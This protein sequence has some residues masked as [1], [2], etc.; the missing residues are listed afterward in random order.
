MIDTKLKGSG[1]GGGGGSFKQTPDNL[2][3]D[4]T[5]EGVLGLCIGP[6]KGPKRG[7]K[8]IKVDGTAIENENGEK[9]LGDFVAVL[10]DGDPA[11]HPQKVPLKLGAG[12]APTAVNLA[13]TNSSASIPGPWITK[14][15][16]N[17]G[18]NFIDLR[19]IVNQLFRQ[20]EKGIFEF[21]ATLDVE[22]KPT[23]SAT[24]VDPTANYDV[25]GGG[26][27][28]GS[29][30][31]Y[32][33][34]GWNLPGPGGGGDLHVYMTE[35]TYIREVR[36]YMGDYIEGEGGGSGGGSATL[37]G[38]GFKITAKRTGPSV[39]ELRL[40][41]PSDGAYA[42]KSWDVRVRL[43]E[44]D[45]FDSEDGKIQ[46]RRQISWE[47]LSAVYSAELGDHEDWRGVAWLQVYG[48]ASEQ[49]N[50]VPEMT[51]EYDCKIVSVPATVFDPETRQYT[52]GIWDGSWSKAFTNDPAWVINDAISD[53]LSGLA[54]IASG[55]YLNKWD[56]LE[57]SKW[58]SELV[59]DGHGGTHPRYSLNI[60]ISEDVKAEEFIRNLAGA[61][62]GLAWD[63]GDGE[64]RLKVDKP[65]LPMDIFTLDNVEGEF[66]YSHTDVDT[67]FNDITMAFINAEMDYR[68][69]RVRL[70]DNDH[71]ARYGRKPTSMVAVGCTNRQEALRRT[72]LRLESTTKETR[73]VNFTTNRRGRNVNQL[74]MIL[75]ADGDL[76]DRQNR[77]TGRAVA[78]SP[79]RQTITLR[80]TV[81][82]EVGVDYQLHF[83][84]PN[85]E[86]DPETA[87]QPE[88]ETWHLPTLAQ[89]RAITNSSG[90]RG[91]VTTLYLGSALPEDIPDN[92]SIS[93]SAV[94]LPTLPKL[95][96]VLSVMPDDTNPERVGISALEVNT[97]KWDASDN[98]DS[99]DTVFQDLRGT[100]PAP[101]PPS[102]GDILNLIVVPTDTGEV[103][104]LMG[105]YL[106]PPSAFI[107]GFKIDYSVN[108]GPLIPLSARTS[109]P[110]FEIV[111]PAPGTY[112]VE[113]RSL[114]RRGGVS[115][116]LVEEIEV[117][118]AMI[119]A[120]L[121]TYLDGT[122]LEDLR[123]AEGGA[124]VGGRLGTNI[125]RELAQ[126]GATVTSA[127]AVTS[128]G[129]AA[130]IASQG[131]L[132]TQ[133]SAAYGS[134]ITG[135]PTPI[136]P[137]NLT[138][139][140]YLDAAQMQYTGG[141]GYATIQ[142]LR[143]GEAGANITESR[144]AAAITGQGAL[145]TANNAAWGS[146]ITGRPTEL[147]DGRI[148][149]GLDASGDLNRN[150]STG[151]ANTSNLLR[152]SSGGLF[153]GELAADVTS[154]H[155]AAAITGQGSL[156]T[157]SSAAWGTH[158]SG[159]P[160]ELTD[161]RI[162]AGLD[163]SG[164]LN[165]N[166]GTSRANT[167]NLLRYTSG[168]LFT[169]EL[170]ADVTSTH[171]AAAIT[172]QGALA[173]LSTIT[174]TIRDNSNL[175]GRSGGG[176]YTGD[177]GAT[178][179]DNLILNPSLASSAVGWYINP[180]TAANT[181]VTTGG[182]TDPVPRYF[183][184]TGTA[185][186][187]ANNNTQ[188]PVIGGADLFLS[189]T[190]RCSVVTGYVG[191][192]VWQYNAAG[193]LLSNPTTTWQTAA[194]TWA[195]KKTKITLHANAANILVVLSAF[196]GTGGTYN[197]I[198]L[199]RLAFTEKDATMG[200]LL[201]SGGNI[202][203]DDGTTRLTDA[204]AVT[205]LGTA[206]A[207]A[208]QAATATSSDFSVITGTTRPEASADVTRAISGP[209]DII[210][211][212]SHTGSYLDGELPRN[213]QF[214]LIGADG[215]DVT[216]SATWTRTVVSGGATCTIGSGTGTLNTTDLTSESVVRIQASYLGKSWPP[217][218]VQLRRVAAAAPSSG[219]SG[220][221]T[222]GTAASKSSGLYTINSTS[223]AVINGD[224][225]L[226]VVIGSAGQASLSANLSPSVEAASP[227]GAT[228]V[229]GIW[230]RRT[231][232][233]PDVWTNIDSEIT[234]S[235]DPTSEDSGLG[236]YYSYA[237]TLVVNK[238]VTG[239]SA[240]STQRFRFRARVSGGNTRTVYWAAGSSLSVQG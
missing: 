118:Q 197:D 205:S 46:E 193:A 35:Q 216:T 34:D 191:I 64:W 179:G 98:V 129:T 190:V 1:G 19:F 192:T 145:A 38:D 195:V 174:T 21:T 199:I 11:K 81:R 78:V 117:T 183:R 200:G 120:A 8:S 131:A 99:E 149:A 203:R 167:S 102:S 184:F 44:K 154:T 211:G 155:T 138:P 180:S 41:V 108:G 73:I 17:T 69:D 239:L 206:A 113:I 189:A 104:N 150:I 152:Y 28:G 210:V 75:I 60:A 30:D 224:S 168:G 233:G 70:F 178:H 221:G 143:P 72:K 7:M 67:R 194:A 39:F 29:W 109:S 6:I 128:L 176:L 136:Q 65:E 217:F 140:G 71:I 228:D 27:G 126:G 85:P 103:V 238:T 48:K 97:D 43:R 157:L 59:P 87:T 162:T 144:T 79:D 20:T 139:G 66:L 125:Y 237:G 158:I 105:S 51:G 209:A 146:Q 134:Q 50:S 231:S 201:G 90:Q 112:R 225:E 202:Y 63:Q 100:P 156:A 186:T 2:R 220:G 106:R 153:T 130:A 110:T 83:S 160:T 16:P 91:N 121:L 222:G 213:D 175:L 122:P 188:I 137:A 182:G 24:W 12:A 115:D 93:L 177:L 227:A 9:N 4:D 161:G 18:A 89:T 40:G 57:A 123:P 173:T 33:P 141:P 165:R 36:G 52:G 230:Q 42:D 234:S 49:L 207:I 171:T 68:E 172:G 56:A 181:N 3:S 22:L 124:T 86:Y 96:R 119:N 107:S 47:S 166:I 196:L 219:G 31:T 80:D 151:R 5:F 55:S 163:A 148:T 74:N 54:L 37:A 204:L 62:G 92:L 15:L 53:P 236:P 26:S 232:T 10:G 94:G 159:R 208:G 187:R 101:L 111:N 14:T 164:D 198:G 218:L 226:E 229:A 133:N 185:D 95:Y 77:S 61:V 235:P 76:G 84:S 223:M 214:R 25:S 240:G 142:S 147:T 135:L 132:A 23:D 45:S 170:A 13:V 88:D 215:S 82:L 58:C 116:P 212:V 114:D 32:N 127:M 169:G